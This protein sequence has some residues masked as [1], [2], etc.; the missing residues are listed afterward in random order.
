VGNTSDNNESSE[1]AAGLGWLV[2]PLSLSLSP[3]DWDW[4]VARARAVAEDT[5]LLATVDKREVDFAAA[6]GPA[7][8]VQ[9]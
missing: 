5:A 6:V 4:L 1:L 2:G 3:A 9:C 7:L 8:P